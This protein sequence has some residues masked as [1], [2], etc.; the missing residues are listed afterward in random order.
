MLNF[1][2]KRACCLKDSRLRVERERQQKSDVGF[3]KAKNRH[4]LQSGF[5]GE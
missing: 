4:L 5:F 3:M 2:D 1:K